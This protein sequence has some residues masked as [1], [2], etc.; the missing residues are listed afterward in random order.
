MIL[1]W[2]ANLK[3]D[4]LQP[5]RK[6]DESLISGWLFFRY[7]AVGGYVGAGTVMAATW[8]FSMYSGG[9]GLSYYQLV[10]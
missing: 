4:F 2:Y 6:A 8:W 9:P 1:I 5:P 10:R 7:M 3:F